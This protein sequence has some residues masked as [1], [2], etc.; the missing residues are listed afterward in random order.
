M[1]WMMMRKISGKPVKK[2]NVT[3]HFSV[4]YECKSNPT[5]S[6]SQKL[7]CSFR[8]LNFPRLLGIVSCC[9]L[10]YYPWKQV[11]VIVIYILA[12]FSWIWRGNLCLKLA[13]GKR[14]VLYSLSQFFP[15][16]LKVPRVP[17][18]RAFILVVDFGMGWNE[19]KGVW[20]A[21]LLLIW[22]HVGVSEMAPLERDRES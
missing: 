4:H 9:F 19:G 18:Y 16:L 11:N 2:T 12:T 15:L 3:Q 10:C 6:T 5:L 22:G 7:L 8:D 13:K 20:V 21:V 17:V 1:L 14:C